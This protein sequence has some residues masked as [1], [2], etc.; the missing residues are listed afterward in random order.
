MHEITLSEINVA[1]EIGL[2][3]MTHVYE[4]LYTWDCII[5]CMSHFIHAIASSYT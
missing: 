1:G 3:D 4:S 5:I 2:V